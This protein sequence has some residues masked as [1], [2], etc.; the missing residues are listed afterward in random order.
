M[1]DVRPIDLSPA[2]IEKTCGLLSIVYPEAHH[3]TPAYLDRMYN[4]NPEGPTLGFG[5]Y[6][7]G[8]ELIAH[9][10]MIPIRA[11]VYGVEERGIWPFQLATHPGY[12][13][14]GL[15]T[16]M[17]EQS[18]DV[19]REAGFGFFS[20]VGNAMSTPLFVGKWGYQSICQL[21]VKVGI[22]PVPPSGGTDDIDFVRIWNKESIAWRLALPG[23]PYR[24]AYRGGCG[25]IYAPTGKLGISVE[26]GAFDRSLLPEGLRKFGSANPL[27]LWIG[28]DNSRDWSRSLY[29]DV[30]ERLRPSP[31]NLLWYDLTGQNRTF[32]PSR[33]RFDAFDFD[34]Y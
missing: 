6:D 32:D 25:H 2:G 12:R 13:G 34:A 27:R 7:E 24:V 11:R 19:S 1:L 8:G 16:S 26:V 14:K 23:E 20:G 18:F 22:G 21:D 5:G 31:L 30:P 3:L 9:Y 28:V 4:G 29:F 15:F 33:V 17:T 10:L